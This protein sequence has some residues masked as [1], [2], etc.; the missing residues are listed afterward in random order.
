[1]LK[2]GL[3]ACSFE[4][5]KMIDPCLFR[6]KDVICVTYVD[7]CLFFSHSE[8]KIDAV[9]EDLKSL[10]PMS[11]QLNVEDDV[12]GIHL[13][14]QC[15]GSIELRQTGL[16]DRILHMMNMEDCCKVTMPAEKGAIGKDKQGQ[17]C[18]EVWSYLSIVGMLMY[19]ASNSQPDIAFAVH[20][21][22]C[23]LTV[24][25]EHMKWQ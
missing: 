14:K 9:L 13:A 22:A 2:D 25:N 21:C 8:E 18:Q 19:L 20:Q 6:S 11:F 1:M 7:D 15:D 10:N 12:A 23:L 16:I 5:M 3:I 24:L 17:D 4:Q